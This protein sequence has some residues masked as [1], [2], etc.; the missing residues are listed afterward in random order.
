M[1]RRARGARVFARAAQLLHLA[2][3]LELHH[4]SASWL[5]LYDIAAR[6]HKFGA[7][8]DWDF[9]RRGETV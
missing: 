1:R 2:G 5:W 6:L 9:L 7:S 8:L 3:H 4:A